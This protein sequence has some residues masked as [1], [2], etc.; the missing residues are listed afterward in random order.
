MGRDTPGT[1]AILGLMSSLWHI[2][3]L[4]KVSSPT[5]SFA[6]PSLEKSE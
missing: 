4:R 1:L 6:R 5:K 3:G 2:W